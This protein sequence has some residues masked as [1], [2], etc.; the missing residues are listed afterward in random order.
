MNF[1]NDERV[2]FTDPSPGPEAVLREGELGGIGL[3]VDPFVSTF[4][5]MSR[6]NKQ[7]SCSF[8]VEL[9]PATS[10]L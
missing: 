5:K 4:M 7:I 3:S 8:A 1:V 6:E 2:V 10:H 9:A